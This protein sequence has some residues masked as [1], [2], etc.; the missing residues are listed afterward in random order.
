MASERAQE[1]EE[2]SDL[3]LVQGRVRESEDAA[4]SEVAQAR[5]Q[6]KEVE[7][8]AALY[9]QK[10]NAAEEKLK[11]QFPQDG[12]NEYQAQVRKLEKRLATLGSSS[13]MPQALLQEDAAAPQVQALR[14]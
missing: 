9:H 7:Q 8:K 3:K 12:G 11:N 4:E 2:Q 1:Q 6:A 10:V 13:V 5:A 14:S